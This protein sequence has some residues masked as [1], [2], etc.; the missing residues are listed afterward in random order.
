MLVTGLTTLCGLRINSCAYVFPLRVGVVGLQAFACF[1]FN[2]KNPL[3]TTYYVP[4]IVGSEVLIKALSCSQDV[5][6]HVA[7]NVG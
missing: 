6:D 3:A 5:F 2:V 1:D 7:V 4:L